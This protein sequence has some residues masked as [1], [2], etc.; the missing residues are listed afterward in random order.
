MFD[1]Q[2]DF[3]AV[4]YG[5]NDDP[6]RLLLYFA[7]ELRR[8][9]FRTAGLLQLDRRQRRSDNCELRTVVLSNGE[10]VDLAHGREANAGRCQIDGRALAS[11]AETIEAACGGACL[12]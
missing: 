3:A 11:L 1:A 6:D 9:G 8:K 4:V 2:C 5:V 10:V 12:K 7:S